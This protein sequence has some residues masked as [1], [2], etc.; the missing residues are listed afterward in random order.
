MI[1]RI[2]FRSDGVDDEDDDGGNSR[3]R[4]PYDDDENNCRPR[5][6]LRQTNHNNNHRRNGNRYRHRASFIAAACCW[7]MFV[8]VP[9]LVSIFLSTTRRTS[10]TSPDSSTILN[11]AASLFSSNFD[12]GGR[13]RTQ[14]A[15]R[16]GAGDDADDSGLRRQQQRLQIR[17]PPQRGSTQTTTT[18]LAW[19][20]SFPNS[21]TTFT[22]S[23]V[24]HTTGRTTATNYES[25]ATKTTELYPVNPNDGDTGT[26]T[27]VAKINNRS[28]A[29]GTR[30]A[31]FLSNPFLPTG[32]YAL[33]KTHCDGY[34]DGRNYARTLQ[35]VDSFYAGCA[36][37]D[38]GTRL[39]V[40]E[41]EVVEIDDENEPSSR[42]CRQPNSYV[43]YDTKRVLKV[44]HLVRNPYDN[45][46]ARMHLGVQ[47]RKQQ[48]A[49]GGKDDYRSA[50]NVVDVSRFNDTLEGV[51]AWC[52]YVDEIFRDESSLYDDKSEEEDDG[53]GATAFRGEPNPAGTS[54]NVT[55]PEKVWER[56]RRVPCHSEWF[57]YAQ[58]HNT[59]LDMYSAPGK[60]RLV[61]P[62]L[63]VFYEDYGRDLNGTSRAIAEYL[64]LPFLA[65]GAGADDGSG[66]NSDPDDPPLSLL[67]FIGG[68]T[69]G[70]LFSDDDRY[71]IAEL[72]RSLASRDCWELLLRRYF[73]DWFAAVPADEDED[74]NADETKPIVKGSNSAYENDDDDYNDDDSIPINTNNTKVVWLLSFP[75]SVSNPMQFV[76]FAVSTDFLKSTDRHFFSNGTL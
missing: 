16:A 32:R 70:H 71:A 59:A 17:P 53:D 28:T 26:T 37:A 56:M 11:N 2:V 57:R 1:R 20:L 18:Y 13:R 60:L 44:V 29:V 24:E 61:S 68:K 51:R 54:R 50:N 36:R 72:I 8:V 35:T 45:V 12:G 69:Y 15:L 3:R 21:G 62:P 31:P 38:V 27:A 49:A 55:I 64:E 66:N 47:L 14:A 73:D 43:Y 30:V 76:V 39:P 25:E 10:P 48:R 58:W 7:T 40:P 41:P 46:V 33:T 67:P 34:D 42:R 65:A 75:Q 5:Q 74:D 22:L 4:P 19:L 9:T 63:F 23:Q 6:R 52:E